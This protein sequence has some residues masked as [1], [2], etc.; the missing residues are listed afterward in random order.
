MN[1]VGLSGYAT[2]YLFGITTCIPKTGILSGNLAL[3]D[4]RH[5]TLRLPSNRVPIINSQ[6]APTGFLKNAHLQTVLASKIFKPPKVETLRERVELPDGDFIDINYAEESSGNIVALFHGLAGCVDSPYIQGVFATLRARG[7]Q[8]FLMHWRGCSGE[9]NRLA[10]A[11]HSGASDDIEWFINF[12]ANR[13]ENANIYAIGY[14]LGGNALLKYL[15]EQ[16]NK[17]PLK[18]AMA[19]SP[20]LVLSEGANQLDTG[21]A[22]IYQRYLLNL[23]RKQHEKKRLRYPNLNLDEA[24]KGLNTFWKFDNEITAPIHGY[25]GV[26]DYYSR[27]SARQFL[28]NIAVPTR[29]LSA[30]DDPFFTEAILPDESELSSQVT[31]EISA[32]GGHVGFLSKSKRWLDPHVAD[33]LCNFKPAAN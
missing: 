22:K 3:L 18:G 8:P 28:S 15:G 29:I 2:P 20:P 17:S 32:Y 16:G 9:P 13:F 25:D 14:S 31:L 27:C 33:T 10:R 6:F 19:V 1:L 5:S 23:M 11:Y 21:F 26:N 24:H 12:L 4:F 30:R 7:F